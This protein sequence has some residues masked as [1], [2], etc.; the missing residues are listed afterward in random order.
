MTAIDTSLEYLRRWTTGDL[1]SAWALLSPDVVCDSPAGRLAGR[2]AVAAFM[3]PFAGS[4]VGSQLLAGLGDADRAL[5]LYDTTTRAVESAPAAELHTVR[6]GVITSIRIIFDR[7]P[8][9]LARGDV[10]P[11][12]AG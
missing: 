11:V 6:D 12:T 10:A 9:A 5:L 4:L 2:D 3:A 7:L 8:F 1:D